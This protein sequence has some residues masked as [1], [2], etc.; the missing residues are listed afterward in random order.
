MIWLT[1]RQHRIEGLAA[2]LLLGAC[3]LVLAT[4]GLHL[5]ALYDSGVGRCI[6]TGATD[7]GCSTLLRDFNAAVTTDLGFVLWMNFVPGF[8]GVFVG[9]PL[10]A[11]ELENRTHRFAWTQTTTRG[12]WLGVK[13]CI[14]VPAVAVFGALFTALLTWWLWPGGHVRSPLDNAYFDFQGAMPTVYCLFAFALGVAVGAVVRRTVAAM[15]ATLVAF[16]ACRLPV[17]FLLRQRY[18]S[19]ISATVPLAAVGTGNGAALSSG[20]PPDAWILSQSLVDSGG[21]V[22]AADLPAICPPI[23]GGLAATTQCLTDHGVVSRVV[24]QPADR[25]WQFQLIEA[26]IFAGLTLALLAVAIAWVRHRRV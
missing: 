13:L 10:L 26:L 11:R 14:L 2:A 25:F 23:P 5:H 12:R 17:E 9:G 19:P 8:A 6:A 16:L 1:W 3:A 20:A 4:T 24:Y 18:A 21:T 7:V 15:A 22:A